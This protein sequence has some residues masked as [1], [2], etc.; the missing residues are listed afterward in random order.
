MRDAIVAVSMAL[1]WVYMKRHGRWKGFLDA[2]GGQYNLSGQGGST[3]PN[4][5]QTAT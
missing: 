5:S 2:L 4:E 1:F 3:S